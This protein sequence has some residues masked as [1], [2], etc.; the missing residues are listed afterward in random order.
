M[1]R[2]TRTHAYVCT[3]IEHTT[4]ST[5]DTHKYAIISRTL[6]K[7]FRNSRQSVSIHISFQYLTISI[8]G[9]S[10]WR[11]NMKRIRFRLVLNRYSPIYSEGNKLIFFCTFIQ[12]AQN[13][14]CPSLRPE[15]SRFPGSQTPVILC[16]QGLKQLVLMYTPGRQG[17]AHVIPWDTV[18]TKNHLP[19]GRC[20]TSGP[21]LSP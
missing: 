19:S 15:N 6:K 17:A 13:R 2:V 16:S 10:I 12:V 3:Y 8:K 1:V 4:R 20:I 9:I 7:M 5:L 18:P 21:P 11:Q 14:Q